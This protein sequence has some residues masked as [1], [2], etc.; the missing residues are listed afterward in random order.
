[1][2][3]I[4]VVSGV[5]TQGLPEFPILDFIS[6]TTTAALTVSFFVGGQEIRKIFSGKKISTEDMVVKYF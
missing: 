3:Y 1:M 2:G 5:A 4:L 6:R